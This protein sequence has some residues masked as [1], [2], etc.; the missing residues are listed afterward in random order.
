MD[1]LLARIG[2]YDSL[3][4][5]YSN[6][7]QTA[8][9]LIDAGYI[10]ASDKVIDYGAGLGRVAVPL[11]TLGID[12]R[13]YE[14]HKESAEVLNSKGLR[15]EPDPRGKLTLLDRYEPADVSL[16]LFVLQHLSL[17]DAF[18]AVR[19]CSMLSDRLI[20]TY[21]TYEQIARCDHLTSND[22]VPARTMETSED[23][24]RSAIMPIAYFGVLFYH[25][26]F[27]VMTLREVQDVVGRGKL[28][29]WEIRK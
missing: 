23:C 22:F 18:D 10:D 11:R 1:E 27:D 29:M 13:C 26:Q 21:P 24:S 14:P 8:S 25:T 2:K 19:A 15:V 6:G 7:W 9:N 3:E 5:L 17:A 20:F 4:S 16:C 28:A 12:I